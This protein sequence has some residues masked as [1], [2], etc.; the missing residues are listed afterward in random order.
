[1]IYTQEQQSRFL[2]DEYEAEVDIFKRK[3]DTVATTL[4][5]QDEEM[6]VGQL[7][8][9][10]NGQMIMLFSNNRALPRIGD[11]FFCM[12]LA[13]ELRAYRSW[14]LLSYKNL[15]QKKELST[16]SVCIWH[17]KS[18]SD[19]YSLVGFR[20]IDIEFANAME[21][22]ENV[23][24]TFGPAVPPYEYLTNLMKV[25]SLPAGR[26][27]TFL[28]H[29]FANSVVSPKLIDN[30]DKNLTSTILNLSD[31]NETL[32][33]QGPPGTGKTTLLSNL[34]AKLLNEGN[35][36]LVTALTNR[37]L[38]ELA[39]KSSIKTFLRNKK[40]Y[41]TNITSDEENESPNLMPIKDIEPIK[42]SLVMSTFYMTSGIAASMESPDF[43]YVIVDEAS[44]AFLAMLA[45]TYNL[46][47]KKIWVGDIN[48]LPPIAQLNSD[49][50]DRHN[51]LGFVDGLRTVAEDG[52]IP[53][54]QLHYTFRFPQ[55]AANYT[56]CFYNGELKSA[57]VS[58]NLNLHLRLSNILSPKGGPVLIK[59]DMPMGVDTAA[60]SIE[61]V[62]N[63]INDI[64]SED[65][66]AKIAVLSCKKTSVR[67][68]QKAV[69]ISLGRHKDL[70][71]DTVARIQG[72]TTEYTIYYIPN[73]IYVHSLEKRL[74]N[75]ATSRSEIAT[76]LIA[77]QNILQYKNM[78]K[79]VRTFLERLNSERSFYISNNGK[80][81]QET[82]KKATLD[83]KRSNDL[84]EHNE[85]NIEHDDVKSIYPGLE[86]IVDQLIEANIPFDK[87]GNIDLTD[88]DGE[89]VASAA[90]LFRDKKIAI[91]PFDEESETEF[92]KHGYRIINSSNFDIKMLEE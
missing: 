61:I 56:A 72:L 7:A 2:R 62:L 6:F 71:I 66:Q 4:L 13:P 60:S 74:F 92:K 51:Y 47:K 49:F 65:S 3:L 75:V 29:D 31:S 89:V 1:M 38:M 68:L 40:V 9:M 24:L 73:T 27:T 8:G 30:R 85:T 10:K 12:L 46:G 32:I 80:S 91:D 55:R 22:A 33:I 11:H 84:N 77:D 87:E 36:I 16:D 69:N 81:F 59:T 20:G 42:G 28:Q 76:I 14:G 41:K 21:K 64:Y 5:L 26:S 25:V 86:N 90:M 43:D 23:I 18:D 44:Q 57:K 67:A 39:S 19:K 15:V 17:S 83:N 58:F 54:Y 53:I 63:L 79:D 48:Q 52:G 78:H 34:C 82:G 70:I 35:S 37:A 50:I 88:K 45:A